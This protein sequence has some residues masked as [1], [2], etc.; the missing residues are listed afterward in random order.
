MRFKIVQCETLLGLANR[1]L[2][3]WSPRELD[4]DI[5]CA[6]HAIKDG[7]DLSHEPLKEI[8]ANG[9]VLVIQFGHRGWIESPRYTSKME[10]AAGL[11]PAGLHTI[12]NDPRIVCS[13]ALSA[14]AVLGSTAVFS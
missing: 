7:N 10:C 8:R 3:E 4:A 1:C 2:V 6:V 9:F 12:S 14:R 11:V 13:T 5:Y